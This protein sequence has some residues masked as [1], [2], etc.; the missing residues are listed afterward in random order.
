[1]ASASC[2]LSFHMPWGETAIFAPS[3]DLGGPGRWE[4]GA[5]VPCTP[6]VAGGRLGSAEPRCMYTCRVAGGALS[7]SLSAERH[8][9]LC[10]LVHAR[11]RLPGAECVETALPARRKPQPLGGCSALSRAVCRQS[12]PQE[13]G[14]SARSSASQWV[15]EHVVKWFSLGTAAH[16]LGRGG[17]GGSSAGLQACPPGPDMAPSSLVGSRHPRMGQASRLSSQTL[18]HSLGWDLVLSTWA[19]FGLASQGAARG[20]PPATWTVAVHRMVEARKPT[21]GHSAPLTSP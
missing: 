2:S 7:P 18:W 14:L 19:V 17:Q 3:S 5:H 9:P 10:P 11:L 6:G 4:A 20:T 12:Y 13:G 15:W 1:M 21:S 8:G 16:R